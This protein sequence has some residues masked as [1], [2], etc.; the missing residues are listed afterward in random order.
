M[1]TG[2]IICTF[3]EFLC[4]ITLGIIALRR[5]KEIKQLKHE[6]S[7]VKNS[8]E[9]YKRMVDGFRD[10]MKEEE[11]KYEIVQADYYTSESDIMKYNSGKKMKRAIRSKLAM[12]IGNDIAKRFEPT[13]LPLG[14]GKEKY[15]LVLKVK[16]I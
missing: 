8:E 11:E 13:T 14:E 15:S 6:L 1:T 7:A 3:I 16:K 12:L 4:A 9:Y 5:E 10:K 2:L